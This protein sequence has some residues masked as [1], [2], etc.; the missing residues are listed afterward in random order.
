MIICVT[1]YD[2]E[3]FKRSILN[4]KGDFITRIYAEWSSVMALQAPLQINNHSA[5]SFGMI[6]FFPFLKCLINYCFV[7]SVQS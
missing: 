6:L 2:R 7:L 4:S 3:T 5:M 1:S